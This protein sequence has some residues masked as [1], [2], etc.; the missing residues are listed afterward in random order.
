MGTGIAQVALLAGHEV[1]LGD[2]SGMALEKAQRALEAAL[3]REVEKGRLDAATAASARARLS[4]ILPDEKLAPYDRCAI[5]IEAVLEDLDTKRSLFAALEEVIAPDCVLATNT[6]SL[7]VGAIAAACRRPERVIGTHFFNPAP[8]MPL[9]EVV[10]A[11][12]TSG[13]V[14]TAV[15]ELMKS[16]GKIVVVAS[17]TPG[18]IVNRIA[19]PYY[20]EALCVV[21]DG[22]ADVATVDWAA[23]EL[24][25]FKMGPFELMDFIGNDVNYA[26]TESIWRGTYFDARYRPSLVQKRLVEAGYLGRKTGRGFYHY[27]AGVEPPRPRQDRA[28]GEAIVQRI[29]AMLVNEA[30]EAVRLRIATVPDVELAM[31]KGVHYPKGLLAWGEEL[32]F[33]Q[34]LAELERLRSEFG[35]ER[36]RPS[37]LLRQ[38]ALRGRAALEELE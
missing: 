10:P 27:G 12:R 6:S 23:R 4:P 21:E 16:W 14:L 31:T 18:F 9:V 37:P 5:V 3:Q 15:R 30:V 1:L 32:G 33:G 13:D 24:A 8:V 38:L 25:G 36:Y 17:D 28:L 2:A 26:V 11:L 20:G 29:L 22:S 19:R 35:S 7:S 34:V